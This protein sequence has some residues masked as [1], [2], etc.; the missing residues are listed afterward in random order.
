MPKEDIDKLAKNE[1][2]NLKKSRYKQVNNLL[3]KNP[4]IFIIS[5]KAP[6]TERIIET[7]NNLNYHYVGICDDG[8][9]AVKHVA[10]IKPDLIFISTNLNDDYDGINVGMDLSKYNIPFIYIFDN[11][12][13]FDVD[14]FIMENYGFIYDNYNQNQIKFAIEI[15]IRT[16]MRSI[17]SVEVYENKF[18]EKNTELVI[19][20]LYSTLLLTLSIILILA[21]VISRN[22]TF[23][24]WIIFIPGVINLFL[25]IVSLKKQEK[26]VPY[27]EPPFVSIFIP[28][29]N[30]EY[31]IEATVRSICS[32]D[33]YYNNKINF[34]VIVVNDG[35]TDNTGTI[36]SKLKNEFNNLRIITRSPP[37]SGKGKGFVL[38]DALI[39]AKGEIIGVF[40]ADTRVDKK[41]LST[42]IPY[43]NNEKVVAVQSRVRM[44][45]K[46]ENFLANMQDI[47]FAGFGN[48]LRAKDILGYEAFLGGNGQFTKKE[49]VEKAG[50][51][52][53]FAVT[54]DL[55][56]S[57]KVELAGGG[58]RY[59]PDVAIYQEAVTNWS[60]FY[61]QRTRWAIGNFETLFIF[62][63]RIIFSK[64]SPIKKIGII[65][66]IA[67]Y[68]FNLFIFT[69]F[70]IFAINILAWFVWGVPT[71]IRMEAPLIIGILSAIAFFPGIIIALIRDDKKYLT[72]LKDLI[73]Y[74]IYCFYLIPLF[75]KTMYVMIT[76]RERKWDKTE[77]KGNKEEAN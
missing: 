42:I 23:I 73:G 38:N 50:K 37:K 32:M 7:I 46:D 72:F 71:I 5:K 48:I 36:L 70:I 41:Y 35:S 59:C 11:E 1:F 12:T 44:Y 49:A 20:K 16:S 77:H 75:F 56:L 60:D 8:H 22:V 29:H 65:S 6:I 40:D 39:L 19:E 34:E 31:T 10:K 2:K 68:A 15:A 3:N 43:L 28:A 17:H 64:L 51:W 30:E 27:I 55:N 25:A 57:I 47:E 63:S 45:N 18:H 52:D 67:N 61:R 33:Y 26:P 58:V 76:R 74:W 62:F 53:G 69:G 54:E 66:H 13:D 9:K 14:P 4:D 21:G 24:Q